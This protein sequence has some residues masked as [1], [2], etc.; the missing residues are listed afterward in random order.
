MDIHWQRIENGA[1]PGTPDVNGCHAGKEIWIELKNVKG[2][3]VKLEPEQVNWLVKRS[4]NKGRCWVLAKKD[5][6][7]KAWKGEQARELKEL[8]WECPCDSVW[9]KDRNSFNWIDMMATLFD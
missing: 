6:V 9:L 5:D 2:N 7:I 3:A 4:L 1:G 8:G